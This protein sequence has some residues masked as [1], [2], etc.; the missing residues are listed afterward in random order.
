MNLL[1]VIDIKNI[2]DQYNASP[3]KTIGQNF[4]I[5]DFTLNKIIEAAELNPKDTILEIGPGLG[6]L[7]K[8]LAQKTKKIIAIEKDNAMVQILKETLKDY[9]NVEII[10]GNALL[11][12]NYSLPTHYKVVAN[13]PYYITSPI[14][15]KFLESANP[16]ESMV[17]MVQKEVGQR[18]CSSPPNMSLLSVSVQFYAKPKIISYISKKCFWPSPKVDSAIIKI[19]PFKKS[20]EISHEK[21]FKIVKSGFSQPRKQ[22]AN[23]FSKS[24]KINREKV[25]LWLLKNTTNPKQ[26]AETLSIE[27][28]KNLANSYQHP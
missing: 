26:R 20:E 4:L 21:F 9:K 3:S 19:I 2:L 25:N 27:D 22:L 6:G 24:L 1:S 7:T 11:D 13:I 17:L 12:T 15:R 16:P 28:W 5:D 18:I 23:N 10:H 14:I 8:E